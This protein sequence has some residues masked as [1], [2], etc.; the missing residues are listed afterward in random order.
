MSGTESR[1]S[2]LNFK[3]KKE[4]K[5]K[6][7]D[8]SGA[9]HDH[10]GPPRK[11]RSGQGS[12]SNPIAI[13]D[14][15]DYHLPPN[16]SNKEED[17]VSLWDD[18]EEDGT[19]AQDYWQAHWSQTENVAPEYGT[20]RESYD[21]WADRIA[22]E[23]RE[24]RR[25]KQKKETKPSRKESS[26][27]RKNERA[28]RAAEKSRLEKTALDA[29]RSAYRLA[30]SK[31]VSAKPDGT[32]TFRDLP[33]PVVSNRTVS[34]EAVSAFLFGGCEFSVDEKRKMVKDSLLLWHPDKFARHK[35]RFTPSDWEK[36]ANEVNLISQSLNG[37]YAEL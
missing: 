8:R 24:K 32:L 9:D 13:D 28:E 2:R 20:Q 34:Q 16:F 15:D 19:A 3:E 27:K 36:I 11:R 7:R 18:V 1:P 22:E 6:K 25:A 14:L 35:A 37:I 4:K 10:S 30:W 26:E 23:A 33:K 31:L 21:A 12:P 5:H 17:F 29:A